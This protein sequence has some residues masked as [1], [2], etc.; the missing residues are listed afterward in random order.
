MLVRIV[1]GIAA[2]VD[3]MLSYWVEDL[4][5]TDPRGHQLAGSLA[6]IVG[7][8]ADLYAQLLETFVNLTL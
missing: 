3:G 4:N 1:V 7:L 5:L 2:I 6:Q 8:G